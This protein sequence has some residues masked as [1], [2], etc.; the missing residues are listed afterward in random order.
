[1]IACLEKLQESYVKLGSQLLILQG[2]PSQAIPKL[3]LALDSKIVIWNLDIEPYSIQRDEE[4]T[5]AL[6]AQGIQTQTYWD[7]LLHSPI[8]QYLIINCLKQT[9]IVQ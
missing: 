9:Q 1:M 3:A 7:Q 5:T 4:V 6:K 2:K 8:G